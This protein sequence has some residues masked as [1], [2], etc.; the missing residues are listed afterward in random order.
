LSFGC[1]AAK[2]SMAAVASSIGTR[3]LDSV[4]ISFTISAL[5][6]HASSSSTTGP[7]HIC[8]DVSTATLCWMH[9]QSALLGAGGAGGSAAFPPPA[10]RAAAASAAA[11]ARSFI[12]EAAP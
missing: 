5:S 2:L 6:R 12:Q 8:A 11:N 1:A 7:S 9:G 4:G 3:L 10:Q